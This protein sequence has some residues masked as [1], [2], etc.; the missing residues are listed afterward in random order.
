MSE[1]SSGYESEAASS[2]CS[3]ADDVSEGEKDAQNQRRVRTKFSPEQ[4]NKLEKIFHKH[5]YLDAGERVKTAQK[6]K[7]TETQV[8]MAIRALG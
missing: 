1:Y 8:R 4:I 2:E 7:L 5:K 6:L 3:A